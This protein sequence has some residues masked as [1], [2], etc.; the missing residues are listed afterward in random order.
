MQQ[1]FKRQEKNVQ[2]FRKKSKRKIQKHEEKLNL[3]QKEMSSLIYRSDMI[4]GICILCSEKLFSSEKLS[5]RF[6]FF[7][8]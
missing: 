5:V 2:S 8:K 4:G 1:N 7:F 3:Q 6:M